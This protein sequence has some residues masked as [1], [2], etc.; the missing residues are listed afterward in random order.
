MAQRENDVE[1][2]GLGLREQ[3]NRLRLTVGNHV[4]N[5]TGQQRVGFRLANNIRARHHRSEREQTDTESL[6]HNVLLLR[7]SAVQVESESGRSLWS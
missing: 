7:L 2:H 5:V 3:S 6:N 1:V 4:T